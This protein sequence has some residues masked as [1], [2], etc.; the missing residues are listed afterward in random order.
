MNECNMYNGYGSGWNYKPP[1]SNPFPVIAP[2]ADIQNPYLF[3]IEK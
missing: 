2:V 3:M 1:F